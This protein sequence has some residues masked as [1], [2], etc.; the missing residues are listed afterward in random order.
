MG[1]LDA[2]FAL[3]TTVVENGAGIVVRAMI[4]PFSLPSCVAIMFRWAVSRPHSNHNADA[5]AAAVWSDDWAG[6][7]PAGFFC[8]AVG[9]VESIA[10]AKTFAMKYGY[11]PCLA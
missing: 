5:V 9:Y 8:A 6:L 11:A 4:L 10:V 3:R 2:V 7:L 1:E